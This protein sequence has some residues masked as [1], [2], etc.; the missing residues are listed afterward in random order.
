MALG[1]SKSFSSKVKSKT[2]YSSSKSTSSGS[3]TT[4]SS[5]SSSSK[6]SSSSTPKISQS[7]N[8]IATTTP[9]KTSSIQTTQES[10]SEKYARL[11]AEAKEREDNIKKQKEI[12]QGKHVAE[13]YDIHAKKIAG[14]TP[15]GSTA[16]TFINN[17][18]GETSQKASDVTSVNLEAYLGERGY[19]DI[20]ETFTF[21]SKTNTMPD[22]LK[23]Q[24]LNEERM[25]SKTREE[26]LRNQAEIKAQ[27][28]TV[29]ELNLMNKEQVDKYNEISNVISQSKPDNSEKLQNDIISKV[30]NF[31]SL[32]NPIT[33]NPKTRGESEVFATGIEDSTV[34]SLGFS[35]EAFGDKPKTK[36]TDED[37]KFVTKDN[38]VGIAGI[39]LGLG[40]LGLIYF[41]SRRK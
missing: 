20:T 25:A 41:L 26:I 34:E 28:G 27:G 35:P 19:G 15:E 32:D 29:P 37:K 22:I 24:K 7:S 11:Q 36:H 38:S 8:F 33:Q 17:K 14:I 18:T 31:L 1:W 6:S 40:A 4:R 21:G 9:T 2:G 3:N 10:N 23:P 5:I 12:Q 30:S 39:G 13:S 16:N